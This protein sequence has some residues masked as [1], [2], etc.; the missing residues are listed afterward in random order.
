[1]TLSDLE[2]K[3]PLTITVQEAAPIMGVTPR[4]LQLALQQGKFPFGIG[5][6]MSQWAYYINTDRF[7]HYMKCGNL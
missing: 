3:R 2:E 5:V 1:M 4:F 7:I 6:E